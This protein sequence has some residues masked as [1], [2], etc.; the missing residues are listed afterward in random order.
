[1]TTP[2]LP[3]NPL[4]YGLRL[5]FDPETLMEATDDEYKRLMEL[6]TELSYLALRLHAKR[7]AKLNTP[8]MV[9]NP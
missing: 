8:H 5:N 3:D 4:Y 6:F 1:M 9:V 7:V 2:R